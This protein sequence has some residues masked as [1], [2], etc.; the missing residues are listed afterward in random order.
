MQNRN[1]RPASTFGRFVA[2]TIAEIAVSG[3]G[4]VRSAVGAPARERVQQRPHG[5]Q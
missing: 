3:D 5:F 4:D 2:T 1:L